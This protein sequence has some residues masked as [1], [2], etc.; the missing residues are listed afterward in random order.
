MRRLSP[1][2]LRA[3]Q[4]R[5]L[6]T[7]RRPYGWLARLLFRGLDLVYGRP[8]ALSKFKVLELIEIGR[9]SCRERV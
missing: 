4:A 1:T 6:A 5:T 3:E 7:P 2:E 8:R 9:A